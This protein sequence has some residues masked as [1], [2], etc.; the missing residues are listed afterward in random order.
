VVPAQ[1]TNKENHDAT[2]T[3]SGVETHK[4]KENEGEE[5]EGENEGAENKGAEN[6]GAENKGEEEKG[7]TTSTEA[8][9]AAAATKITKNTNAT[10]RATWGTAT[11]ATKT[12]KNNNTLNS[13]APNA[14]EVTTIL[15]VDHGR[16]QICLHCFSFLKLMLDIALNNFSDDQLA[17][18]GSDDEGKA[19]YIFEIK[20]SA[21]FM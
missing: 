4:K 6:K 3:T 15:S 10:T 9:G 17:H 13:P 12:T 14:G 1:H 19:E 16:G 2:S 21:I 18:I 7:E 20:L 5:N 11:A 8:S